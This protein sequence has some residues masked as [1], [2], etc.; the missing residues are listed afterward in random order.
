MRKILFWLLWLLLNVG[1]DNADII[2]LEGDLPIDDTVLV[3]IYDFSK[4]KLMYS[5]TLISASL[6]LTCD[7]MPAGLYQMVMSWNRDILHPQEL[8]Y[9]ARGETLDRPKFSLGGT[10]W[11]APTEAREHR[12]LLS[13]PLVQ[14]ELEEELLKD[15]TDV[16]LKIISNG[17]SNMLYNEYI[18]L[19]R[20]HQ[21]LNQ[22]ER[23]RLT[24]KLYAY[25]EM[26]QLDSSN[27]VYAELKAAWIPSVKAKLNAAEI[28]FF[29]K[30]H[31]ND[32][33]DFLIY[34]QI[35]TTQDLDIYK[36]LYDSLDQRL[37][38]AIARKIGN[39]DLR[40]FSK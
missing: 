35:N 5:D 14:A 39:S 28:G 25:N 3:D 31:D 4:G 7:S 34:S 30:Y 36:S 10:F 29:K 13:R 19:V 38:S 9:F 22:Q 27:S 40:S 26:N 32:V 20:E 16:S 21:L 18:D 37:K 6:K 1:C 23:N 24:E 15:R 8:K 2:S 11:L 12:V 17:E 33:V